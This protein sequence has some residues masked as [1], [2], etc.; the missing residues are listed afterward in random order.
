MRIESLHF[1]P[2][3]SC[4]GINADQLVCQQEGPVWDREW[5]LIHADTK[6]FLTQRQ[7]PHLQLVKPSLHEHCLRLEYEGKTLEILL[8]SARPLVEAEVWGTRVQAGD[9]GAQAAEWFSAITGKPT[10]LVR[11]GSATRIEGE[12]EKRREVRFADSYPLHIT[13]VESLASFN[14]SA[15]ASV[16]MSRFRAN[17]VLS[18]APAWAEDLWG[19]LQM[20][21]QIFT[22]K[23][24]TT[25]CAITTVDPLTAA[26]GVEPLKTLAKTRKAEKGVVFG[27]YFICPGEV[28]LQVGMEARSF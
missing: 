26:R 2:V 23:K 4:A 9:E 22:R 28:M 15:A 24:A 14:A 27:Q 20:G 12:D 1:Y 5:M 7:V 11:F 21:G 3:K 25:R 17:V 6:T 18:G 19:G 13:T 10:R 8:H 16:E